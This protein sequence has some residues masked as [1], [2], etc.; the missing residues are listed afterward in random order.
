MKQVQKGFTL[1][2][3]MIVVAIIGILAAVAI[4][5]YQD[6]INKSKSTEL[7]SAASALRLA[8]ET[9]T[10]DQAIAVGTAG[11]AAPYAA[12]TQNTNGVPADIATGAS[13]SPVIDTVAT[14]NGQ[15]T[16]TAFA[17]KL[18]I[19]GAPGAATLILTPTATANGVKWVRS[20]SVVTD[21]YVKATN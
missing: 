6:Y 14:L 20:G 11:P 4:P 19:K 3:L 8:I 21:G 1:I 15:V 18:T 9:C 10:S 16:V 13:N 17:N 12:C 5:A 2:E 7:V